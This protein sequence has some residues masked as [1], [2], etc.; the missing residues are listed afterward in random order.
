M[1]K[2]TIFV[3]GNGFDIYHGVPSRYSDFQKY[4]AINDSSLHSLLEKFISIDE[5]W[6]ELEASLADIDVDNIVDS[7]SQFLVPY[8]AED[9]SDAYHH[10]YQYEVDRI[11]ES[12]SSQLKLRFAEWVRQLEIPT[13]EN[14]SVHP[15]SLLPT[16]KFLTFNYTSSLTVVYGVPSKNIVYIHGEASTGEELI[17]GHAWNPIEIPSLNDVPDPENLDTRVLEGNELINS[18]FGK[19]FKDTKKVIAEK[20]AFFGSLAAVSKIVVLGHS[21]SKVD[22]AYFEEIARSLDLSKVTWVVTY[23]G[24]QER[25]KHRNALINIGIPEEAISFRRMNEL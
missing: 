4:L 15:L 20:S 3:I 21:L 23:Y 19:T 14:L 11:I 24:D 25:E 17:L 18:Y 2:E 10:D 5:N 1:D 12:L 9:W 6:S 8:G 7:L 13:F 16:A 22:V